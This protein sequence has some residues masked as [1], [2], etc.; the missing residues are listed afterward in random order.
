VNTLKLTKICLKGCVKIASYTAKLVLAEKEV[1]LHRPLN[2]QAG[3]SRRQRRGRQPFDTAILSD[4]DIF[5][6]SSLATLCGYRDVAYFR[7]VVLVN[8]DC[9]IHVRQIAWTDEASRRRIGTV[10]AT[11]T[12]SALAGG[13][14]WCRMQRA[15]AQV[16]SQLLPRLG[17]VIGVQCPVSLN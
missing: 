2:R 17:R 3:A 9:P 14:T 8:S 7:D 16:R 11:H 15:A 4:C 12:N 6:V 5:A 1:P 10:H 13:E